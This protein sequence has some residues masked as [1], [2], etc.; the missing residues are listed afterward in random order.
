MEEKIIIEGKFK[1]AIVPFII[2]A[3]AI[4]FIIICAA[5]EVSNIRYS[6]WN[7]DSDATL[8]DGFVN[9]VCFDTYY[10]II[11]PIMFYVWVLVI[12]I[13][14]LVFFMTKGC[15]ITVSTTRV[16]GKASFGKRV[17]LPLSQISAIGLGIFNS[18][19]ISTSSGRVSFWLLSN[20]KDVHEA[21]S[22]Q[23]AK[24]QNTQTTAPYSTVSTNSP[25]DELKK[26]K[27]LL[28]SGVI[29]QEEFDAKK[30][31]LLGF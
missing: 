25:A 15:A 16:V 24:F 17:D 23:I 12:L 2:C 30:K 11:N 19:S 4:L 28:D 6:Y 31:H 21:L 5:N 13:S 7:R 9:L 26:Y 20:R 8:F 29:T 27:E 18:I 3:I 14:L 1:K 10:G 22:D